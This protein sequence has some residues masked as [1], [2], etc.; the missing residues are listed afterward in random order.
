MKASS[1]FLVKDMKEKTS[2]RYCFSWTD[3]PCRGPLATA[4]TSYS[5]W[6]SPAAGRGRT[7]ITWYQC[8]SELSTAATLTAGALGALLAGERCPLAFPPLPSRITQA[9]S[10]TLPSGSSASGGTVGPSQRHVGR[11]PG[12]GTERKQPGPVSLGMDCAPLMCLHG[13]NV[14][15]N[16]PP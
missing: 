7:E 3:R 5:E 11:N 13:A 10:R 14:P 12:R 1:I 16:R 9:S 2:L 6:R 4:N 15:H 8:R